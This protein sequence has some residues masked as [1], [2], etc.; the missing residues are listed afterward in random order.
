MILSSSILSASPLTIDL[1]PEVRYLNV[2]WRV[3]GV[4]E[5]H[6]TGIFI[7]NVMSKSVEAVCVDLFT[8]ISTGQT[9]NYTLQYSNS[10]QALAF[11]SNIRRAA[12][13]FHNQLPVINATTNALQQSI[14]GAALQAAVWDILID[15][16]NGLS[17]GRFQKRTGTVDTNW[18]SV[19]NRTATLLSSS[20]G[21]T[22]NYTV[23]LINAS[24]AT[25]SQTLMTTDILSPEPGTMLSIG[26]GLVVMSV[27]VRRRRKTLKP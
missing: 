12:W 24:G 10:V 7:A 13:L 15:N 11:N 21:K 23:T 19:Y 25:A 4:N 5:T 18:T 22:Y 27:I 26:S 3:D 8:D 9:Y 14:N 6:Y 17:A 16:G 2:G 20:Q 1:D